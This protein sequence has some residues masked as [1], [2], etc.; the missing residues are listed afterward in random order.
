MENIREV[1]G[2][3]GPQGFCGLT[4]KTIHGLIGHS[5][6]DG[7][8]IISSNLTRAISSGAAS[9]AFAPRGFRISEGQP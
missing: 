1:L 5:V 2:G 9:S 3:M 8:P 4:Y 7:Y 6:K